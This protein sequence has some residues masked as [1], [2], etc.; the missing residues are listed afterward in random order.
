MWKYFDVFV[1]LD[2]Y[3]QILLY[4]T[5]LLLFLIYDYYIFVLSFISVLVTV[6]RF[7][8]LFHVTCSVI[9][10]VIS[11]FA[12]VFLIVIFKDEGAL[13][14]CLIRDIILF[15]R[16]II[17]YSFN[18]TPKFSRRYFILLRILLLWHAVI[19]SFT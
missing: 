19:T 5:F 2:L 6:H 7:K 9:L 13:V 3:Y 1:G 10:I 14:R 8:A 15:M 18:F 4:L 17:I 12:T 16:P 11:T